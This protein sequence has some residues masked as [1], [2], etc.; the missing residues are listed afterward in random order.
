[1]S[2]D[3]ETLYLTM[4]VLGGKVSAIIHNEDDS[5]TLRL[6]CPYV[7]HH[8]DPIWEPMV[9]LYPNEAYDE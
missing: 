2:K 5:Y 1:M 6:L 4:L 7:N 3:L 8:N 9:T